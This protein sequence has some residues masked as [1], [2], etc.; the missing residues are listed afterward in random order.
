MSGEHRGRNLFVAR[1]GPPPWACEMCD[2]SGAD[3]VHH[4]DENRDNNEFSNLAGV[5]RT[6]HLRYHGRRRVKSA[7]EKEKI[8]LG[9][10]G[11]GTGPRSEQA[12]ANM[13][14]ARFGRVVSVDTREKMRASLLAQSRKCSSCGMIS[15]PAALGR[16]QKASGHT[17]WVDLNS[18]TETQENRNDR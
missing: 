15:I 18:D 11:K 17:G 8:S 5:H 16:H 14:A 9:R 7:E 6:C 13:N 4:K 1:F 10:L 3:V 2:L 12:R